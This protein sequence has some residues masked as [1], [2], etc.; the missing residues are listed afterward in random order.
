MCFAFVPAGTQMLTV[1]DESCPVALSPSTQVSRWAIGRSAL[2]LPLAVVAGSTVGGTVGGGG[3]GGSPDTEDF[4]EVALPTAPCAGAS[5]AGGEIC[6]WASVAARSSR[7][8]WASRSTRT[9][10]SAVGSLCA[11]LTAC[12][13]SSQSRFE[14]SC[15]AA[16]PPS[17]RP[18]EPSVRTRA[19]KQSPHTGPRALRAH[20]FSSI[21]AILLG[22][23][24]L[25]APYASKKSTTASAPVIA[26]GPLSGGSNTRGAT[27]WRARSEA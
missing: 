2:A 18:P 12:A 9:P 15:A 4:F 26:L 25:R 22:G 6:C 14:T 5:T 23:S 27:P 10:S 21:P 8:C 20:A 16:S 3:V 24:P 11:L 13:D 1:S 7:R 17:S 19:K